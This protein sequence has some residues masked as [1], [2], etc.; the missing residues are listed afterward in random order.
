ML[1][2]IIKWVATF[3]IITVILIITIYDLKEN[4]ILHPDVIIY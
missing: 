3:G 2:L 1:I 4:I